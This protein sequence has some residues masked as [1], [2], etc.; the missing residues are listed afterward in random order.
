MPCLTADRYYAYLDGDLS[1]AEKSAVDRHLAACEACRLALTARTR[2]MEA[3]AGLP[4][5]DLPTDFATGIMARVPVP[6]ARSRSLFR[7][8]RIAFGAGAATVI[9]GFGLTAIFSG[10]GIATLLLDAAAAFGG[11]LHDAANAFAKGL[12]V[13]LLA[14]KVIGEI[15]G[16]V[17]AMLRTVADSVGPETQA[18]LAVGSVAILITGG[19]FLRRRITTSER[20][21]EN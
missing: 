18:V 17:L 12:K 4:A 15:A 2:I 7:G 19:L 9:L 10:R 8:W 14:G 13:L 3:A 5:F 6:A 11:Y 20:T 1:P 16:Q 21:Y